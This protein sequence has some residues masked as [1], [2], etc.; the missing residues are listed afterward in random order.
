MGA[1]KYG[2]RFNKIGGPALYTSLKPEHALREANQV[3]ALQPTTLVS[4]RADL[5][6]IFDTTD[7][8]LM[9]EYEISSI[10]LAVEDWRDRML[11]GE[12][13]PS[14]EF[15]ERLIED[16]YVGVL[17]RSFAPA[18]AD[19]MNIVLWEWSDLEVVDDEN[20]LK[21]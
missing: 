8:S 12:S 1:S 9:S 7:P 19:G 18:N 3:G 2:G 21:P 4:Y 5:E 14:Q 20:R 17:V 15:A 13:V 16:G 10:D 11:R 6:P